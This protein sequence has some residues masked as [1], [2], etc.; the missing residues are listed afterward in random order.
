MKILSVKE[1]REYLVETDEEE[2]S[3]Y[4][5]DGKG[6][7]EVLMGCSWEDYSNQDIQNA[8]EQWD[9]EIE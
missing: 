9:G 7:W 3:T 2:W 1:I 4:R 8:L 6:N 5:T